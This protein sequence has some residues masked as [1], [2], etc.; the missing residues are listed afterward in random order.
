MKTVLLAGG[1]GS[2]LSEETSL[3]P[4]PMVEIGGL[5][6]LVHIMRIYAHAG[7]NEFI[8]ALGYRGDMIREYFA[9]YHLRHGD[10]TIHLPTGTIQ[11]GEAVVD[12]WTVRLVDTGE[13]SMT[14]GR[15]H[16]LEPI[17]RNDG[18]FMLT[19]GDGVADIDV[20]KLLT[21]HKSHG[22]LATVTAVRPA[23]RFGA[24]RFDGDRVIDFHEK[25]QTEGG[26]ING[27]FFVFEPGVFDYLQGDATI[28][29]REPLE[30]LAADGQLMAFRHE[31]FWHAMD[32]VRDRDVLSGLWNAGEAP[33]H[34]P[35]TP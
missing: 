1:L 6:M 2:R 10:V 7:F 35:A 22:R 11:Y 17:L 21:F 13:K 33:W 20:E 12:D 8:V 5:P 9:H 34:R 29:E 24:M 4:K 30:R 27:G 25:P 28:L 32:T 14:G 23:A 15:L 31:G 26:W 19:Y 3:R 18:T 16:R